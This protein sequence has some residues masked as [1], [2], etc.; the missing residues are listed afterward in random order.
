MKETFTL[1]EVQSAINIT[2]IISLKVG[3]PKEAADFMHKEVPEE[4]HKPIL[5]AV[6][7]TTLATSVFGS[8]NDID[9]KE[10]KCTC[11]PKCGCKKQEENEE[12]VPDI[13]KMLLAR[14][15]CGF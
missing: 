13:V 1:E 5:A 6:L 11:S 4:L 2:A 3:N 8:D 15:L 7:G 12:E 10:E 14:A 9:E